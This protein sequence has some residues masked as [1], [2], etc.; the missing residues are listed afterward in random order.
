MLDRRLPIGNAL[1]LARRQLAIS[2]IKEYSSGNPCKSRSI[3]KYGN[4][5]DTSLRRI[6]YLVSG[7]F[8]ARG[9]PDFPT[10]MN[11]A[12]YL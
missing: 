5:L 9:F 3:T 7:C 6:G 2:L 11:S 8:E 10:L 1:Q 4:K 12:P